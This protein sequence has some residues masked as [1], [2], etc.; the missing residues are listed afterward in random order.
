[1]RAVLLS[2]KPVYADALLAGTKKAEIRRRFPSAAPGTTV[3]VYASSPVR[4]LVGTLRLDQITRESPDIVW[5]DHHHQIEI[6]ED[7]LTH[8]LAGRDEAAML[9]VSRPNRWGTKIPLQEMREKLRLEPP[10]SF[11]YL[12]D[13]MVAE[14]HTMRPSERILQSPTTSAEAPFRAAFAR[15]Q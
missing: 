5:R 2:V 14:L 3:F 11:R 4:A 7:A 10:Q 13:A 1:M 8:Y 9:W 15:W 6:A 12:T